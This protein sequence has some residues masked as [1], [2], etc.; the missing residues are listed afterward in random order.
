MDT[1]AWVTGIASL[2]SFGIQIFDL[3]PKYKEARHGVLFFSAG[4]FLGSL[5]NAVEPSSIKIQV[6]LTGFVLLISA[7]TTILG[8]LVLVAAFTSDSDKRAT[9][10]V[11][12]GLGLIP[13]VFILFIGSLITGAVDN[14]RNATQKITATELFYL[15]EKAIE[16]K[17]Y[18]RAITHLETAQSRMPSYDERSESIDKKIQEI[19]QLEI[20]QHSK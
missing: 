3:F 7:L 1:F 19:K 14:P 10:L 16:H 2:I 18:E 15:S 5:L 8:G 6:H 17:D 11:V 20:Q 12:S 4:L 13:Y 9:L